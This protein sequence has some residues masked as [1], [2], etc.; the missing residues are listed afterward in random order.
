MKSNSDVAKKLTV[1]QL[2]AFGFPAMTHAL[3]ASPIYAILPAFYAA[4]TT[5]TL[6]EIG[7][8]AAVSRIIDALADPVIGFLSDRTRTRIG[9]RKPWTLAAIVLC[10][11]A[12]VNLFSPPHTAT[13]LYFFVWSQ[14][15]YAGFTM[16]EVPRSAWGSEISRDYHERSRIGLFVAAFNIAGSLSFYALPVLLGVLTGDRKINAGVL[17][18]VSYIYLVLMP[19]GLITAAIVV[20]QGRKVASG[21]AK[22]LEVL[23]SALKRPPLRLFYLITILWGL[24]QGSFVGVSYIFYTDYMGLADY[25]PLMMGLLFVT[26]ICVL[27]IWS[28]VLKRFD[29][30]RIWALCMGIGACLAPLVLI[31]P[32]GVEALGPVIGLALVRS[33]F[34]SPTNFLPGAVLGDVIDYDTWK[35]GSNKAGNLFAIQMVLIKITMATGGAIAFVVMDRFGYRVGHPNSETATL[36]LKIAYLGIP[37]IFHLAMAGLCWNFPIDRRRHRAI[38]R[39]LEV[40]TAAAS[41]QAVV[42]QAI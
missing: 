31:L 6:A 33:F 36:G 11:T 27:P 3:I 28:R 21:S 29:R 17:K 32:R 1:I 13:W 26:E 38:L 34:T 41:A 5:V 37:A 15:M 9:P 25:F 22:I 18:D 19:I 4:N 20:P 40:R 2:L 14:I 8:V 30:H 42:S 10:A 16:F 35:S 12:I 39:R 23:K 7:I 24:G